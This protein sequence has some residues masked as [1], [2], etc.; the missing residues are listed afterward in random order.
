[1][2]H[3]IYAIALFIAHSI[4]HAEVPHCSQHYKDGI[5]PII[6]NQTFQSLAR[7]LCFSEFSV[8]HSGVTKTPLWSAQ[9]LTRSRL[10]QPK[11]KRED[12]F[13]EELALPAHERATLIDYKRESQKFNRGHL[14]P[15]GDLSTRQSKNESFSLSNIVPQ[16]PYNN[17]VLWEGVETS[18]RSFVKNS[19]D[20]YV[21]TG[22]LFMNGRNLMS[23]R[24]AIP[25]HMFKL[26]WSEKYGKGGVY[27][28]ENKATDDYK[29]ISVA[30]L[31]QLSGINFLPATSQGIKGKLL[32]LPTPQISQKNKAKFDHGQTSISRQH[33]SS[34]TLDRWVKPAKLIAKLLH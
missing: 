1:M 8:M 32:S 26:I 30:D 21:I 34:P 28:A 12:S 9:L 17:Q 7:P 33:N 19:S 13:H 16:D 24:V 4:A 15:N 3:I 25:S 14:T 6:H 2:K 27:L 11:L 31:E 18:V 23:D 22:V 29:M 5:A 10:E 20:A